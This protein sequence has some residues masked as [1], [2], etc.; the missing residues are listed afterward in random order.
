MIRSNTSLKERRMMKKMEAF[1]R[2]Y[3]ERYH[4]PP[5]RTFPKRAWAK[6]E[7]E[8]NGTPPVE[9]RPIVIPQA[10]LDQ[11]IADV[12]NPSTKPVDMKSLFD[13]RYEK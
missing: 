1:M 5:G 4:K 8:K 7:A 3:A 9:K 2:W 10:F 13:T 11:A 6:W 12:W